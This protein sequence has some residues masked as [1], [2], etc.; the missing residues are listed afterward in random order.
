MDGILDTI[1]KLIGPGQGVTYFDPDLI[2]HI[3]TAI[4]KLTQL[5]VGPKNGFAITGENE[6][7]VD[8]L[9][10]Q[11]LSLMSMVMDYIVFDVRL[12]FDPP[13]SGT[14]TQ[15]F[16]DKLSELEWRINVAVDPIDFDKWGF[17]NDD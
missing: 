9:G 10:E 17:D 11:N 14:L 12:S 13:S 3:N 7:W 6:T 1:R 2:L 8:F 5:G 16:K 15:T 4:G